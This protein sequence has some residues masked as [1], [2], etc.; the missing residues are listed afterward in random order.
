MRVLLPRGQLRGNWDLAKPARRGAAV[1]ELAILLPFLTFLFLAA[2]DFGRVFYHYLTITNCASNG[3][4]YAS[5]D[6]THA[7]DTS[8][9]QDAALVDATDLKPT[10]SVSSTTG[11]DKAGNSFVQVTVSYPFQTIASFPGIPSYMTIRRTVQ[12]RVAPP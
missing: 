10:Q 12:M 6:A 2:V 4:T 8:G 5:T 3:A 1:A 7:V 11:T 9:I